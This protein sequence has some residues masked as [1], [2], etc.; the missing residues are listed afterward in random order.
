VH[1]PNEMR[2]E[3]K[4]DVPKPTSQAVRPLRIKYRSYPNDYSPSA[5]HDLLRHVHDRCEDVDV[6]VGPAVFS[7]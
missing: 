4:R 6:L 7:E 1:V 5:V 2:E 3:A